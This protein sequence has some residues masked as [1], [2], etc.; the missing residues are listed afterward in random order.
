MLLHGDLWPGNVLWQDGRLVAVVDWEDGA[1][2]A[3][4]IDVASAR[5][6]LS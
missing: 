2:G 6:D 3:P 1:V 5:G 4:L